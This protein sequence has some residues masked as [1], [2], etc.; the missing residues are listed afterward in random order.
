[1]ATA[2][3]PV[4][5]MDVETEKA[6]AKSEHKGETYYFCSSDCKSEFDKGPDRFAKSGEPRSKAEPKN[7]K[8]K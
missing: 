3:D 2:K 8:P 1:M 4:C 6:A 7:P 5:H